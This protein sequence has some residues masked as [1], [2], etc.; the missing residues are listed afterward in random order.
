RATGYEASEPS[1]PVVD[2]A[3]DSGDEPD[4]YAHRGLRERPVVSA[5][6]AAPVLLLSMVP[7]L[8]FDRWQWAALTL[9]SPVV[10]WGALPFHRATW[11]NLRHGAATMDTLIS[12]GVGAAYLWS[13]WALFVGDAGMP[14]ARMELSWLP[15]R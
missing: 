11:T 5:V 1:P 10:V 7:A 13:L 2:R 4:D 3:D 15:A 14:G 8:Q 12:L 9:A 6:L